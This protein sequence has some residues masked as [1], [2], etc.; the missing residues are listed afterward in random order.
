IAMALASLGML[1]SKP[2]WKGLVA[3]LL[4]VIIGTIGLDPITASER[5]TFGNPELEEGIGLIPMLI[6][7]LSVSEVFRQME[8]SLSDL[9]SK[10]IQFSKKKIDNRVSWAE[11][12][13]CIPVMFRSS[14]LGTLIGAMP[15][16]GSTVAA[17]L[18]YGEARRTSKHPEEF[19]K[20]SLEGIA[21]PEAANNA[22]SGA[23][24]IP[25][26]AFGIPGDIAAALILSAF[27][28]QG[29]NVGPLAFSENPVPLYA[30]YGALIIA[31]VVNLVLG[32]GL[33]H[34]SR[35]AF[36]IPRRL[37]LSSVLVIAS[38]GSYALRG[39]LFDVQMVF[40]F[41]I[42]GYAMI[43][44]GFPT[45]PLL[46]GFI[47]TPLL[48]ENLRTVLLLAST[49]DENLMFVF[50]RP[51]FNVLATLIVVILV[52]VFWR[53]RRLRRLPSPPSDP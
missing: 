46:I 23:N 51:A 6:G 24:L 22:V 47:L 28:I 3:M 49:Y 12:K 26:L 20:G 18:A 2:P 16:L 44:Y 40:V 45:V 33:V 27:M 39:S 1:S 42:L 19:G 36:A 13:S 53:K 30:I 35:V 9:S 38:A 10:A 14:A 48:E 5:L 11:F 15:G 29:I 7:F 31:N 34:V 17:F 52:L 32:H 50:T 41:G 37:L 43:R 25:L 21:A 8:S 4:G